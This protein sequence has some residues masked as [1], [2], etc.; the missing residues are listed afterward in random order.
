MSSGNAVR[1]RLSLI[2]VAVMILPPV[3]SIVQLE[4]GPQELEEKSESRQSN[5]VPSFMPFD[6]SAVDFEDPS[7]GWNWDDGNTGKAALY[8]RAASYVP[9][10]DWEQVTGESVI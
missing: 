9:I 8:Y 10:L 2:L 5:D 6:Q 7:H 1:S 4:A 3:L